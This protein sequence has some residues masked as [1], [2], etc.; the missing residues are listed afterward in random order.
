MNYNILTELTGHGG[1]SAR[2]FTPDL[3]QQSNLPTGFQR[4]SFENHFCE[5]HFR[6]VGFSD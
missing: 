5:N 1:C 4:F 3:A 2:G 6:A